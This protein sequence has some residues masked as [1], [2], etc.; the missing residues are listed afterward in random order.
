[1]IV[2]GTAELIDDID[3]VRRW[4]AFIGGRYMGADRAE[5]FGARNGVPGEYL[6]RVTPT[7]V[8]VA[9]DLSDSAARALRQERGD[10]VLGVGELAGGGHELDRVGV[11]LRLVE[12]D[13][14]VE[15][16]LAEALRHGA[17]AA[18]AAGQVERCLAELVR[19]DD[20]GSRAP[21]RARWRRRPGHP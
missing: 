17:A 18:G 15:P 4:A 11:G 10:G 21:S 20:R 9:R 1:M 14:G 2:E 8:V 19:R 16:R 13:L 7:H 5:E 6:V 3:E 12:V